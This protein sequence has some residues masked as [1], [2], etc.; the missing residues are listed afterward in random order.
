MMKA[1][2]YI[3]V[4]NLAMNGGFGMRYEVLR[5]F[6]SRD[7]AEPVRLNAYVSFDPERA[8]TNIDYRIKQNRFHAA[9]RDFG[10]KVI[11]KDT[12]WYTD[13]AGER[14]GKSNV[15][16]DLAV[17]ALLQ[18]ANLD[19]V[20]LATGDGDFVRVVRALQN[21]GC[22]VEVVAFDNVSGS[23]RR[24]ADLYVSG[25]LIPN[26]L[27]IQRAPADCPPWGEVGS[28]V[29]GV[30]YA[31]DSSKGF[32]WVRFLKRLNGDI[33]RTDYRDP[34]SPYATIFCHDSEFPDDLDMSQLTHRKIVL[35]F[36][37]AA[38]S[39]PDKHKAVNVQWLRAPS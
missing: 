30:C 17:D 16:L 8:D 22:R 20:V 19:R 15:D 7:N 35:E 14:F 34:Q 27:P 12:K 1:G 38:G 18:S 11:Q 24:E 39:E 4:A 37:I 25:Y 9:L 3:D 28:F 31:H 26:L 33:W 29:R 36:Q 2:V 10:Y 21:R 5:Q 32:G 13:D 23:L 6:A